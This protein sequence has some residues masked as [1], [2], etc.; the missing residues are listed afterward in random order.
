MKKTLLTLLL[1]G[2]WTTQA[3]AIKI[4]QA[5]AKTSIGGWVYVLED[6]ENKL[7]L[8]DVL[9][10]KDFEKSKIEVPNFGVTNSDF[11]IKFTLTNK[12]IEEN[13]YLEV[14]QPIMDKIHFYDLEVNNKPVIEGEIYPFA[15][16]KYG[17]TNFVFD[18][19]LKPGA[20]KTYFLKIHSS[21]QIQAPLHVGTMKAITDSNTLSLVISSAFFGLMLVMV[22]YNTFIYIS[23][24][25]NSYLYYV[26]YIII[27]MLTQLTPKGFTY[28]YF[29]PSS[30]WM[31]NHSMFLLPALVGIAGIVFFNN[32]LETKKFAPKLRKIFSILIITYAIAIILVF[33]GEYKTGYGI[34]ELSAMAVA[35]SMLLGAIH[36]SK[37]G[38]RSA[39]FFLIAW[40]VFLVGIVLWVLK[41]VGVLPYNNFTRYTMQFG[42]A[43]ETILLSFGLA[44]RIN[45][46]RNEKESALEK[47]EKL[48]KEQNIFLEQKVKARTRQLEKSNSQLN[49][50][51]E[52]LK[53]AQDSLVQ[54]EK[55]AS[56]GQLT[57][58]VA[59]EINNPINFVSSNILPLRRD[60]ND[61]E[62]LMKIYDS[63]T[64]ENAAEKLEEIK[65]LKSE[66][67]Y[68]Y[69]K[70]ELKTIVD[71]IEEGAKRTAYIVKSL[72]TFS[73]HDWEETT[74]FDINDGIKTTLT[75]LNN[76]LS[77]F[78]LSLALCETATRNCYPGQINQALMNLFSNA[79]DSLDAKWGN[80][81]EG[82][83]SITSKVENSQIIIEIND[84]GIGVPDEIKNKIFDP[85]FTTKPVG[86][87]TGLG[88]S[89]TY[90]IIET[91]EG[92]ISFESS[93]EK[94]TS[95]TVCLPIK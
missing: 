43:I 53:E 75:L 22:L 41:D 33:L 36:I 58:G 87:G 1:L 48:I 46:L 65:Q 52:T 5:H 68:D 80:N 57:A 13:I 14:A 93:P 31:A 89:I 18:L 91:H 39:K 69:L 28:Q 6:S 76:R 38:S 72:K 11:W 35:L 56:L 15:Q 94:G 70:E 25:D 42:A 77:N 29:W 47:N 32:F 73:A 44:D 24:R 7:S 40:S 54:S 20:T 90:K 60:L 92:N 16:R 21:E 27:L 4:T 51:I 84:N 81:P 83:L 64:A 9:N 3:Q 78:T 85:F 30:P 34:I 50:A 45:I 95:F 55:M 8:N 17:L 62:N 74:A 71:G 79:L 2:A 82:S 88:L 86:Q 12:G 66:I 59:H 63:I 37:K 23:T 19:N 67:E 26:I 49:N 10:S 61:V